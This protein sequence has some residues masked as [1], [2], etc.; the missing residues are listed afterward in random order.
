MNFLH[1]FRLKSSRC[2]QIQFSSTTLTDR[3]GHGT[4]IFKLRVGGCNFAHERF[5]TQVDWIIIIFMV[6]IIFTLRSV[7][8]S[9]GAILGLSADY[10]ALQMLSEAAH[11][12]VNVNLFKF[13]LHWT[14]LESFIGIFV[15]FMSIDG[16]HVAVWRDSPT[17]RNICWCI[18]YSLNDQEITLSTLI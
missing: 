5:Y 4:Q 1:Q 18:K 15:G 6:E 7:E 9:H 3:R 14:I 12:H 16:I 2:G 13:V 8:T 11:L 10:S 17:G